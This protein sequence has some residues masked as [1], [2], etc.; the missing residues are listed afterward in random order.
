MALGQPGAPGSSRL[1]LL[2]LTLAAA[3]EA[4]LGPDLDKL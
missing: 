1:A 3:I 4:T 2:D